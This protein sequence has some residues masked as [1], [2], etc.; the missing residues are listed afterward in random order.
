[1][2]GICG[3][4]NLNRSHFIKTDE[5]KRMCDILYHRGPDEGGLYIKSNVGLGFRRLS[6][7]DL[8]TGSQPIANEYKN[9]WLSFNGEIFNFVE[10]RESLEKKG[11]TFSTKS[12]TEVIVHLYEEYGKECVQYLRGMFAFSVWDERKQTLFLARD[13]FG[14]K[15]LYFYIDNDKLIYASE[16]KAIIS[17]KSICR[18]INISALDSYF[19]YGYILKGDSIFKNVSKLPPAHFLRLDVLKKKLEINKYWNIS[20]DPDYS[21]T[22]EQWTEEIDAVLS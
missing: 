5:I 17:D 13:R 21:K 19:T 15:P 4:I 8:Q 7:I 6:I 18:K 12:D 10:L 16:I 1:M 9:I 22:K 11:H 2:C 20:F 3:K 14:I